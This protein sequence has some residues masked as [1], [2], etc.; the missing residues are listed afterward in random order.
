M[1]S[2]SY[3][4]GCLGGVGRACYHQYYLF[5]QAVDERNGVRLH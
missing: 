1:L 5:V 2:T 4:D 3:L